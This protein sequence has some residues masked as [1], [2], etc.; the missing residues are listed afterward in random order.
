MTGF[1]LFVTDDNFSHMALLWWK[2]AVYIFCSH[3]FT[4]TII[5]ALQSCHLVRWCITAGLVHREYNRKLKMPNARTA[6]ILKITLDKFTHTVVNFCYLRWTLPS[7]SMLYEIS[8]ICHVIYELKCAIKENLCKNVVSY[9]AVR[10]VQSFICGQLQWNDWIL[11]YW[12][13]FS[14]KKIYHVQTVILIG[15]A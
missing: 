10:Q 11:K 1:I 3:L 7:T 9:A 5:D 12:P 15:S 14:G 6:L 2:A 4:H 8:W 13:F